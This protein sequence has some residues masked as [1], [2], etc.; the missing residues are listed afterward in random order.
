MRPR[1]AVSLVELLIALVVLG[2]VAAI[3]IPRLSRAAAPDP[4]TALRSDLQVL[5]CAIER[6]YQDHGHYPGARADGQHPA[7]SAAAVIAQLTQRSDAS[8]RVAD[9]TGGPANPAGPALDT[10]HAALAFGPYL[11]DGMPPCPVPPALGQTGLHVVADG[12]ALAAN[13]DAPDA[14]WVY[15]CATGRIVPNSG[16]CSPDGRAYLDY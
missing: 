9:P 10:T 11:R 16:A 14:G 5:R 4:T 12:R 8:G 2:V 13:P 7:G 1:S 15:D 3:A 6:Y